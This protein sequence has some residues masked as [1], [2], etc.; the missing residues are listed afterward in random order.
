MV[1][2]M[3]MISVQCHNGTNI[4]QPGDALSLDVDFGWLF[5]W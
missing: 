2:V 1:M 4:Y 5:W 3:V